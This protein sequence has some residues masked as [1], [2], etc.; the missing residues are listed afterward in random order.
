M[1]KQPAKVYGKLHASVTYDYDSGLWE[2]AR[3]DDNDEI[4]RMKFASRDEAVS[5][6]GIKQPTVH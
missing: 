1:S 6:L 5:W 2:A 3:R 4:E